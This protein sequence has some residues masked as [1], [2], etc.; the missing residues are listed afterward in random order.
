[1]SSD[2]DLVCVALDPIG[3][4]DGV[5]GFRELPRPD[6]VDGGEVVTLGVADIIR[7]DLSQKLGVTQNIDVDLGA[8]ERLKLR[9]H[10]RQHRGELVVL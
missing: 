4:I 3:E 9:R 6:D 1:M 10:P 7:G 2:L 5:S 8:R